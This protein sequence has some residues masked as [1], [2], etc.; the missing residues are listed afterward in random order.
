MQRSIPKDETKLR[1]VHLSPD[2]PTFDIAVKKGDV[3]FPEVKFEQTTEYL[4]LTPMR[5]ELEARIAGSKNIVLSFPTL[6]LRPDQAY[7]L[8]AL[9]FVK[10]QPLLEVILLED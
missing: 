6:T 5:V 7:T 2:S 8:V 1:F 10:E 3:V 9:G 4:G